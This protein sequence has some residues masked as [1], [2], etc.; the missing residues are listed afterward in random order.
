MY[1]AFLL[2]K[3]FNMKIKQ[4][5]LFTLLFALWS[6][7][8]LQAQSVT[9]TVLPTNGFNVQLSQVIK[10]NLVNS[11]SSEKSVKLKYALKSS[12]GNVLAE[13]SINNFNLPIGLTAFDA[14]T[15]SLVFSNVSGSFV[16]DLAGS[17]PFGNYQFC[18]EVF[19][20]PA[21]TE[22]AAADC[23]PVN[24]IL[25]SPPVLVYPSNKQDVYTL[26]PVLTWL[27]PTPTIGNG[28]T[29]KLKLVELLANQNAYDAIMINP[30]LLEAN[31]LTLT[32]LLYPPTSLALQLNKWYVWQV[33]AFQG[34]TLIGETEAWLFRPVSQ[35]SNNDAPL[36]APPMVVLDTEKNKRMVTITDKLRI[37][38]DELIQVNEFDYK[39]YSSSNEIINPG[40]ITVEN[41]GSGSY[42]LT[43]SNAPAMNNKT[44]TI[45]LITPKKKTLYATF[46]FKSTN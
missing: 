30:A 33:T 31:A 45:E 20:L 12:S 27:A 5:A 18:V 14:N 16:T 36:A 19:E 15:Q 46:Q 29:Y 41:T 3:R 26:N 7:L 4:I 6:S 32:S 17:M 8:Q 28:F 1:I 10:F 34:N 42:T 38:S 43:F 11:A 2:L 13:G 37:Q 25:L 21:L 24:V 35:E 22:P 39:I 9:L 40:N 44:F 23:A